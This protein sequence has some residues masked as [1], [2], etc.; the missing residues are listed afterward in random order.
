MKINGMLVGKILSV[1]A[2][3]TMLVALLYGFIFANFFDEGGLIVS[4]PWGIITLIDIYISFLVFCGWIIFREISIF[5]K[6]I[7]VLFVL[8]LGSF[9]IAI[10]LFI[11]FHTSENN[12]KKF[13]YGKKVS[14][15]PISTQA[16]T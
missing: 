11:A 7:W 6:I 2:F 12:W 3:I 10:Y 8:V 4:V 13:W 1:L 16:I 5:A 15:V 14:S 9:T